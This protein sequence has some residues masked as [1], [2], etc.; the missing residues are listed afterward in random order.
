V[1]GWDGTESNTRP[2]FGAPFASGV[3]VSVANQW[4]QVDVTTQVQG[5]V[6]TPFL[7]NGIQISAS[8]A[9][10]S[11]QVFFDLRQ[12]GKFADEP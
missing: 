10:P 9:S 6:T 3:P 2:T 4:V 8:V 11:T 1:G 12:Q 5:W 7:N